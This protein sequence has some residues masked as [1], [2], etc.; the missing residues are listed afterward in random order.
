VVAPGRVL[1]SGAN[2]ALRQAVGRVPPTVVSR[3]ER[4]GAPTPK[5][6]DAFFGGPSR[7]VRDVYGHHRLRRPDGRHD[8]DVNPQD[9]RCGKA[10]SASKT[11]GIGGRTDPWHP[12]TVRYRLDSFSIKSAKCRNNGTPL[13]ASANKN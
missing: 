3:H 7:L 2:S 5:P 13:S 12:Y 9:A 4:G 11:I 6:G 10:Q 1:K 8:S